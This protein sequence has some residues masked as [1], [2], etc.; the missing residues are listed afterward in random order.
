MKTS[1]EAGRRSRAAQVIAEGYA[2]LGAN[3]FAKNW[4]SRDD[5]PMCTAPKASVHTVIRGVGFSE[6][7]GTTVPAG[8]VRRGMIQLGELDAKMRQHVVE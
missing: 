7:S 1:A 8:A 2:Y 3:R 4:V 5:S 6:T